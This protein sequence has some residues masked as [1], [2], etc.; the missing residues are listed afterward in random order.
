MNDRE[1]MRAL[2]ICGSGNPDGFTAALCRGAVAGLA[3]V[4]VPADLVR[5]AELDIAHCTGCR[6]CR[7]GCGCV[8]HDDMAVINR[9]FRQADLLICATPIHFSGP[10]SLLKT[11]IDRLN[12]YWYGSF[13]H[14]RYQAALLS[15]GRAAPDFRET[16]TILKA[17]GITVGMK[18]CGALEVAGTDEKELTAVEAAAGD[19]V[20]GLYPLS[21]NRD[22][23]PLSE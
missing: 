9:L 3:A 2:I 11:V 15:G 19:F 6:H 17:C 13:P 4:G 10:S 23:R 12:P 5:P 21:D 8:I 22:V 7:D 16:E 14:P 18:W 20:R 1:N